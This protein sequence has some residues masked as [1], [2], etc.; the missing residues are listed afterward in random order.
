MFDAMF[1]PHS[2]KPHD[3]RKALILAYQKRAMERELR[4][5]GY[6]KAASVRRTNE[7]F[8]KL[9]KGNENVAQ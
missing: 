3:D 7:H 6:S 8:S 4:A 9:V 1:R 2:L 5:K